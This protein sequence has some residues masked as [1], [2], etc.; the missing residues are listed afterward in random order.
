MHERDLLQR[1]RAALPPELAHAAG[2]VED[3]AI[4]RGLVPY[5][6]GG[7]VRDTLLGLPLR[8]ADVVVE[9]DAIALARTAAAALGAT[10]RA[11]P[12]FGTAT[13]RGPGFVLDLVTA[14]RESY[15]RPG[16]LPVVEPSTLG[17]DLRRRDFSINAMALA[18]AGPRAGELVDPADGRVALAARQVAVL[19]DRSFADDPTRLL[20][21]VRYAARLDFAIEPHT[22]ALMER[23]RDAIATLT[24]T[25]VRHELER[26]IGE[27]EPEGALLLAQRLGLL[28]AICTGFGFGEAGARAFA[29]LRGAAPGAE[30]D[31]GCWGVLGAALAP[32][33]AE[34]LARRIATTKRQRAALLGAATLAE[35]DDLGRARRSVVAAAASA[36]PAGGVWGA[37][38]AAPQ[39]ALRAALRRYLDHDRYV[40]PTVA[41][42]ELTALG[43]PPGREVGRIAAALLAAKLDGLVS[44]RDDE[45]ALVRRELEAPA[46]GTSP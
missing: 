29:G 31:D 17:D 14:R 1:F 10:V 3:A 8:D 20:R 23:D 7:P 26:I 32:P 2:A 4:G 30:R 42:A 19:H 40:T 24:A 39:G 16:A 9:G 27:A 33:V 43:V 11:H 46:G 41:A 6:A 44:D 28:D 22:L 38:L 37:A 36:H 15:P 45:L 21:A 34:R 35:R 5:A 12:A 18:L 13:L 25:R